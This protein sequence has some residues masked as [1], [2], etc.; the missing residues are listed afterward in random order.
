MVH[1]Q[2]KKWPYQ[3]SKPRFTSKTNMDRMR[4]ILLNC[5][6]GGLN[7]QDARPSESGN[8]EE[9][10][11]AAESLP[12]GSRQASPG[13]HLQPGEEDDLGR[14]RL[15]VERVDWNCQWDSDDAAD[16]AW[17]ESIK[18]NVYVMFVS[19]DAED[20]WN[21]YLVELP[22]TGWVHLDAQT[23]ECWTTPCHSHA[24][25]P[26]PDVTDVS[27]PNPLRPKYSR[28]LKAAT[29]GSNLVEAH[30]DVPTICIPADNT[31][32]LMVAFRCLVPIP[33]RP[34][35]QPTGSLSSQL[36]FTPVVASK[37]ALVSPVVQ[38]LTDT[39]RKEQDYTTFKQGQHHVQTNANLVGSWW[40]AVLFLEQYSWMVSPVQVHDGKRKWP[41]LI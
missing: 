13:V 17:A 34:V 4:S 40:F 2:A 37:S 31:L 8:D 29:A 20:Q 15:Q 14:L 27:Y 3:D 36:Q 23:R 41:K 38:W 1:Q 10:P 25:F 5:A 9:E 16:T 6:L 11:T 32:K 21:M 26:K 19:P 12:A 33:A 18:V 30:A 24:N 35:Q 22:R 7:P 28:R 39:A